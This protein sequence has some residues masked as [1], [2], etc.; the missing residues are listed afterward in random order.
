MRRER[1]RQRI[2][3]GGR[4]TENDWCGLPHLVLAQFRHGSSMRQ[5]KGDV[6]PGGLTI[7]AVPLKFNPIASTM[8]T[9]VSELHLYQ[10]LCL[11]AT[12]GF[13]L[14]GATNLM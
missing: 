13:P 6:F 10:R 9:S 11:G 2:Q 14:F 5:K 12:L 4:G 3:K 8:Q 7:Q 1:K